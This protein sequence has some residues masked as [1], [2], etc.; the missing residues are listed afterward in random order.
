MFFMCLDVLK[1]Y[2]VLAEIYQDVNGEIANFCD[3]IPKDSYTDKFASCLPII[4]VCLRTLRF[5]TAVSEKRIELTKTLYQLSSSLSKEDGS[6]FD[7]EAT[8]KTIRDNVGRVRT[9]AENMLINSNSEFRKWNLVQLLILFSSCMLS[10]ASGYRSLIFLVLSVSAIDLTYRYKSFKIRSILNYD[11]T[12]NYLNM[13][14][15]LEAI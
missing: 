10:L 6:V 3:Q 4:G 11:L 7:K 9:E 12:T 5:Y 14:R 8:Q 1:D 13:L 2:Q 15:D